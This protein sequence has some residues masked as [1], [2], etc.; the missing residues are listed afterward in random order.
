MTDVH[1]KL[2]GLYAIADVE[3]IGADG[4]VDRVTAAIKGGAA[5][6]QY[7]NKS[8]DAAQAKQQASLLL[9]LCRKHDVKFIV[10]DDVEL[11]HHLGA[12]GVHLGKDDMIVRKA[13]D[14]LGPGSI[15]GVSCYDSFQNAQRAQQSGASYVA[16][17]RFFPSKTKPGAI[18]ANIE[19]L[20]SAR[21]HINI[22]IVAIGGITPDNGTALIKAGADML[23]VVDGLFAQDDVEMAAQHYTHLFRE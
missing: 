1:D 9:E 12:D 7:R 19:L 18:P 22:P 20:H 15:I 10:N 4:L 2:K 8:T 23:A 3:T 11:A 21:P 17:G 14:I 6:I 5:V 13:R 16:F